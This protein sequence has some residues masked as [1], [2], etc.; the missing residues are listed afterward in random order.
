MTMP[1]GLKGWLMLAAL[2]ATLVAYLGGVDLRTL[3]KNAGRPVME[4]AVLPD[5]HPPYMVAPDGSVLNGY[6]VQVLNRAHETRTFALTVDG[7]PNPILMGAAL[8]QVRS[9]EVTVPPDDAKRIQVYVAV[10]QGDLAKLN[11]ASTA[12][13]FTLTGTAGEGSTQRRTNFRRP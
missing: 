9:L 4:L 12:F 5:R 8:Q 6:K 1:G 13:T 3:V 2:S 10:P 11:D 7:L